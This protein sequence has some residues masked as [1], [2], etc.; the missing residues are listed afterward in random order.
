MKLQTLSNDHP[1]RKTCPYIR[2]SYTTN[3]NTKH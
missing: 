3:L 1:W 2:K